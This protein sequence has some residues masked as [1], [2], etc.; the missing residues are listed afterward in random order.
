MIGEEYEIYSLEVAIEESNLH[1]VHF[2]VKH[3]LE[4]GKSLLE[5]EYE[6][7]YTP[8][9]RACEEGEYLIVRYL[10]E[11]VGFKINQKDKKK[12][13]PLDYAKQGQYQDHQDIVNYLKSFNKPKYSR[14]SKK[15]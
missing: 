1:F 7:G 14:M 8:L 3:Y 4:K 5:L 9:H 10:Q 6:D 12:M 13:T 11:T 2:F 15:K